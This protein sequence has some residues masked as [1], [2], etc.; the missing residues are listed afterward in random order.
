MN[1]FYI[2]SQ[3]VFSHLNLFTLVWNTNLESRRIFLFSLF[4]FC[5]HK[6]KPFMRASLTLIRP[7]E[8]V[9][10]KRKHK[11]LIVVFGSCGDEPVGFTIRKKTLCWCFLLLLLPIHFIVVTACVLLAVKLTAVREG[12]KLSICSSIHTSITH[13]SIHLSIHPSKTLYCE[14]RWFSSFMTWMNQVMASLVSLLVKLARMIQ[15]GREEQPWVD[16]DV[17]SV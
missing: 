14:R 10:W 12:L 3:R 5:T 13:P 7:D 4:S 11:E 8:F 1:W 15:P 9:A 6:K 2:S 16:G 17:C